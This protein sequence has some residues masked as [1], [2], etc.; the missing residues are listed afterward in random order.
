MKA[1]ESGRIVSAAVIVARSASTATAAARNL[2]W[3]AAAALT[4]FARWMAYQGSIRVQPPSKTGDGAVRVM[5]Q[6]D[7]GLGPAAVNFFNDPTR[8]RCREACNTL[9]MAALM[10]SWALE[11]TSLTPRRPRRAD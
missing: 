10:P 2:K 8:Q 6:L 5:H 11:I 4:L 3:L 9:A 1:R 7:V